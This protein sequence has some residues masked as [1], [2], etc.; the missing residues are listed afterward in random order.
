MNYTQDIKKKVKFAIQIFENHKAELTQCGQLS[1]LDWRRPGSVFYAV[2]IVFDPERY[3][4]VYITG[5]LGCAVI[6]P[7]CR[8]SLDAMARCFTLRNSD[9]M[10]SV[11]VEY[12]MEKFETSSDRHEWS[13]ETFI[14]DLRNQCTVRGL[15]PP[16]DLIDTIEVGWS[17]PVEF[18]EHDRPPCISEAARQDLRKMDADYAEWIHDCG[19]RVSLSVILW[20]VAL[21]LASEQIEQRDNCQ[22]GG[23]NG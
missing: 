9:R 12:F 21:R 14:E 22:E 3:N 15:V 13:E 7:T 17:S 8:A 5:D 4:A 23:T 6:R 11:N 20:L 10:V 16:E 2:R 18:F 19:K 1:V